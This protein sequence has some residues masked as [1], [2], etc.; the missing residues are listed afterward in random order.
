MQDLRCFLL[1]ALKASNFRAPM[2]NAERRHAGPVSTVR[3]D[4]TRQVLSCKSQLAFG[5]I[6]IGRKLATFE[7]EDVLH[8]AHIS[9]LSATARASPTST[10]R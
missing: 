6:S 9:N 8:V 1:A 10:P 3:V 5:G 7:V 2:V 4:R